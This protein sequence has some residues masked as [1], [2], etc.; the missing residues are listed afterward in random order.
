MVQ[1]L[2]RFDLVKEIQRRADEFE[3]YSQVDA[4]LAASKATRVSRSHFE[5]RLVGRTTVPSRPGR[6]ST[7]GNFANFIQWRPVGTGHIIELDVK[8]LPSYWLVQEIGTGRSA[9]VSGVNP[10]G[11]VRAPLAATVKTQVGRRLPAGLVWS[12]MNPGTDQII[13]RSDLGGAGSFKRDAQGNYARF[14]RIKITEEI[15][16]KHYVG[17]GGRAGMRDYRSNVKKAAHKLFDRPRP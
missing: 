1:L 3:R 17:V 7:Q 5:S 2:Q 11:D 6:E 15:K 10:S 14:K 4:Q 9:Q 16:G 8:K 12:G 13:P